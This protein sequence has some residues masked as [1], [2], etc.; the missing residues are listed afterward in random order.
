MTDN[1]ILEPDQ[2]YGEPK[3]ELK[4]EQAVDAELE[5]QQA[6]QEVEEAETQ[7]DPEELD[8][9]SD[10]EEI[11]VIE[12]DGEETSLDDVRK[13]RDGHLMQSDYTK[14]SQ[15]LS[16]ERK[17]F[18]AERE[19]ERKSISEAQSKVDEMKAM[20]EVLVDEDSHTDWDALWD[21]DPDEWKIRKEKFEKRQK[22]LEKVKA[23]RFDADPATIKAE[24]AKL[25]QA[26]PDWLDKDGKPTETYIKDTKLLN[27]YALK[28]GFSSEEFAQ[29]TKAHYLLTILKAA[30]YDAIQDKG[31]EIKSKREKVPVVTKPKKSVTAPAERDAATVLYG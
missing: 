28:V 15:A 4:P 10:E 5:A 8:A 9:D 2:F 7:V 25:L 6:E 3:A 23:K 22:A 12:L 1:P 24:Q 18:E 19:S 13:W 30:K 14:K 17:T 11:Q 29:M 27:D 16:E 26:N 31:R 20:L 21:S